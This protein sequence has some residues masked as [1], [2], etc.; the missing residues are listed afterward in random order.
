MCS[1][2]WASGSS[3]VS[4][5]GA[6]QHLSKPEMLTHLL[7]C[8]AH[9]QAVTRTQSLPSQRAPQQPPDSA[10]EGWVLGASL[11][12][13]GRRK[14]NLCE[15][16]D[17]AAN[18]QSDTQVL[19]TAK[20]LLLQMTPSWSSRPRHQWFRGRSVHL[21][22]PWGKMR[23][24]RRRVQLDDLMGCPSHCLAMF[25]KGF[26]LFEGDGQR[27]VEWHSPSSTKLLPPCSIQGHPRGKQITNK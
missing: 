3:Q 10:S 22:P 16:L 18:T 9:L 19:R 14:R 24:K 2:G 1:P 13:R 25:A 8:A 17:G 5:R 26:A 27:R 21:V 7:P 23:R 11:G 15:A 20:S 6:Q 12:I 4:L